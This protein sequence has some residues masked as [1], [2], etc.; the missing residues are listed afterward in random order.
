MPAQYRR[1]PLPDCQ[2]G[3]GGPHSAELVPGA[4]H[5]YRYAAHH[6]AQ[7]TART[8]HS[9]LC[10]PACR[11]EPHYPG[12]RERAASRRPRTGPLAD[13]ERTQVARDGADPGGAEAVALGSGVAGRAR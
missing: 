5:T 1:V 8:T 6:G 7:M 10:H 13:Q 3:G 12:L 9:S 2:A 4:E 11:P